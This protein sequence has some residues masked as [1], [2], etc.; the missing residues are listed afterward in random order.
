ML[1]K[2]NKGKKILIPGRKDLSRHF[3]ARTNPSLEIK[4]DLILRE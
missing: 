4:L 1:S 3:F 2:R